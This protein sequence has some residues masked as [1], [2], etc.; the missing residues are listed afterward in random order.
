[1]KTIPLTQGKEAVVDDSDHVALSRFRWYAV[2]NTNG[3]SVRWYAA[4]C[5]WGRRVYMHQ[6]LSGAPEVDHRDGD[7]LNNRRT[8]LRA[9]A[10][11][12]NAGNQRKKASASASRFKGVTKAG[13][14]WRAVLQR[15]GK[16]RHLG[17]FDTE[18][19]AASAYA[20]EARA[21]FGDFA[22]HDGVL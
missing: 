4:R 17:Y 2:K 22:R 13:R 8:N 18:E 9:A 5:E 15:L 16:N 11:W 10:H 14:R 6:V 19:A 20:R 12:Q 3:V 7:G 21:V 1:M